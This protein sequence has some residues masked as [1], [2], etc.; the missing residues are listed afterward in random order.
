M[1][2]ATRKR[3]VLIDGHATSVSLEGP[4]WDVLARLARE[5]GVSV[6]ALIA[7]IDRGR[8][9]DSVNLSSAIRVF[10]LAELQRR[11]DQR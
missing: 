8:T 9:P 2:D 1:D 4:F 3:S 6:N 5:R 10:V 7:Q 11:L